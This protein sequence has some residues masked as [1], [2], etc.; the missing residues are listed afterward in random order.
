TDEVTSLDEEV[1]EEVRESRKKRKKSQLF[2]MISKR[3]KYNYASSKSPV[4]TS[5]TTTE[6]VYEIPDDYE[7]SYQYNDPQQETSSAGASF[8]KGA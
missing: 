6:E 1:V 3:S 8:Q 5:E 7:S 2:K 4:Q